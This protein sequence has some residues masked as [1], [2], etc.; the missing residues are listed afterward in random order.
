MGQYHILINIDRREYV[1][2]HTLGKGLKLR[3]QG[4]ARYGIHQALLMLLAASNHNGSGDFRLDDLL[5]RSWAGDRIAII[6]D[7]DIELVPGTRLFY[8]DIEE[9]YKDISFD[10]ASIVE[11]EFNI[12]FVGN[13][14]R[15]IIENDG[16]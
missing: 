13:S 11:Q 16:Q 1:N 12:P 4:F 8:N 7:Q 15:D 5:I 2:P 6:G 14:W 9:R 3:E 10:V